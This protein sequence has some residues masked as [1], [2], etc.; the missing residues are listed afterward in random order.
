M[1]KGQTLTCRLCSSPIGE[2]FLLREI[3]FG[4]DERFEYGECTGCAT[5]QLLNIPDDMA[6]HYPD[7]YYSFALEQRDDGAFRSFLK[8]TALR[9]GLMF[10]GSRIGRFVRRALPSWLFSIPHLNRATRLLDVGTGKGALL[11]RL[12]RWGFTHLE[13]V[14]PFIE[15][16]TNHPRFRIHKGELADLKGQYDVITMHHSLEHVA[17]PE[18]LLREARGLLSPEGTL[19]VRIPVKGGYFWSHYGTD[20]VQIDPPRHF[21]LFTEQGFVALARGQGF[22]VRELF[23]DATDFAFWGS[24]LVSR[25]LTMRDESRITPA[26]RSD[27]QARIELL[28]AS[29]QSDQACFV[30]RPAS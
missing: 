4:I 18:A 27:F 11:E 19:I 5:L 6:P 23:Y 22:K 2:T 15:A 28:N 16:D 24:E 3:M 21:H 8:A 20:W 26:E 14:D 13:G 1:S 12:A 29:G 7:E 17:D 10:P 30:L 25:G 9:L